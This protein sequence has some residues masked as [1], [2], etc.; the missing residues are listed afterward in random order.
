MNI[1]LEIKSCHEWSSGNDSQIGLINV[2]NRVWKFRNKITFVLLKMEQLII[3]LETILLE[4]PI[5]FELLEYLE[6][7]Q[8]ENI[9]RMHR[10][11]KHRWVLV[12]HTQTAEMKLCRIKWWIK[13]AHARVFFFE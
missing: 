12:L 7:F 13:A 10:A 6:N 1:W 2:S 11:E 4:I 9:F 3:K 5:K 8:K